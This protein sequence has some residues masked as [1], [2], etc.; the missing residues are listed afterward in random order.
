MKES[1]HSK[2][3]ISASISQALLA[4]SR[5]YT[6]EVTFELLMQLCVTAHDSSKKQHGEKKC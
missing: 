4:V 3:R 1:C 2:V 5:I 6:A